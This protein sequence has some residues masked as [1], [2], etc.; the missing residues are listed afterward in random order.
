MDRLDQ[1]VW[2]EVCRLLEEPGRLEQEYRQ[3]LQPARDPDEVRTLE[4]QVA[5]LQRGIT[6]LIDGYAEGL[7]DKEEFEPRI[8][9]LRE[10]L[11]HL[12]QQARELRTLTHEEEELRLV[13]SRFEVFAARVRDGLAQ[14]DWTT[15]RELIRLLV[16]RVEIDQEQV[17]VV[18]RVSPPNPNPP[19]S[20]SGD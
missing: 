2:E 4:A 14:A 8:L 20:D 15:R 7:L 1:A 19:H 9:H 5:K 3:R 17:R 12:E 11:Q 13:L 16:R 6:R 10:R 18:F